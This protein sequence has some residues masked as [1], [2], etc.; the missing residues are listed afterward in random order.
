M[1]KQAFSVVGMIFGQVSVVDYLACRQV[2][3][4]WRKK[5]DHETVWKYL[6]NSHWAELPKVQ[7]SW[8]K[9]GWS[10][11]NLLRGR[12]YSLGRIGLLKQSTYDTGSHN[13]RFQHPF[14][15]INNGDQQDS[16]LY[17]SDDMKVWKLYANQDSELVIGLDRRKENEGSPLFVTSFSS[18]PYCL[19]GVDP[20]D[21]SIKWTREIKGNT[22]AELPVFDVSSAVTGFVGEFGV[23]A[24]KW[25]GG[26][27][28][29][30]FYTGIYRLLDG[31][32]INQRRNINV[33]KMVDESL[34]YRGNNGWQTYAEKGWRPAADELIPLG[35]DN[36]RWWEIKRLSNKLHM[37][38]IIER[39]PKVSEDI[40]ELHW[41]G[42][43]LWGGIL[44]DRNT[45]EGVGFAPDYGFVLFK[46]MRSW[47]VDKYELLYTCP[48]DDVNM[49][50]VFE[51]RDGELIPKESKK[52]K[53]SG[54]PCA[55][56]RES[57]CVVL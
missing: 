27:L 2:S 31:K 51:V 6:R 53:A 34:G 45:K 13:S 12:I 23:C 37:H 18:H 15:I 4:K 33:R 10:V 36:E 30:D 9:L 43:R 38:I 29:D 39:L 7:G 56:L 42:R 25:T 47:R 24:I 40:T 52:E 46:Q 44:C 20:F 54:S 1:E 3:M 19:R 55:A 50:P 35:G 16:R 28:A 21:M 11:I 57:T 26:A 17:R 49:V 5:L 41:K 32:L 14:F 8:K 22:P 48:P